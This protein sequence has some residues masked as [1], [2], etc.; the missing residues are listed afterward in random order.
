MKHLKIGAWYTA[1]PCPHHPTNKGNAFQMTEQRLAMFSAAAY[2][3][4]V[5]CG[6]LV[7]T[8]MDDVDFPEGGRP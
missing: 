6:C 8:P 3:E 1:K 2:L 4:M 7:K 5:K